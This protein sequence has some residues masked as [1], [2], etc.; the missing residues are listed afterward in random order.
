[1]SPDN[2][3]D[4][5]SILRNRTFD[6]LA[7]GE[8]ASMERTLTAQD[9]QL[10]AVMS[11]DLNPQHLDP[12]F[13]ASTRFHGVIAHGMWG[14]A[15]I[16]ALLGTRLPGPGTVYQ[17]QTLRF[18]A[19]VRLG[20][21]L[22][23]RVQVRSKNADTQAVVLACTGTNQ[24]GETVIEGEADVIAPTERIE[25]PRS[26]LPDISVDNGGDNGLS[27]T[28]V[29]AGASAQAAAM[30]GWQ[31]GF[32]NLNPD[33]TVEYD[34]IGSGGGRETFLSGGSAFAG[35]DS[36]LNDEEYEASLDSCPGD[37]G[38]VHLPH[39]ISPVAIAFN[40]DGVDSLNMTPETVAGIFAGE[41]TEWDDEAIAA[42][43]PDVD[44]PSTTIN[45]V[46]RSDE[47]GTT[48]NFTDYLASV[49]GDV[50][51]HGEVG[52]WPINHGEG[53]NGTTLLGIG[54]YRPS[55]VVSNEEICE[56]IDSTTDVSIRKCCPKRLRGRTVSLAA[57]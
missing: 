33:V 7:I 18:L 48:E 24:N 43:N 21:R 4:D 52:E 30:K 31:A 40:L 39:Y 9:I 57:P 19:P 13:A 38:A 8:C 27:G 42:D 56:T 10:F 28:L 41:I 35:T 47:S 46:H 29:G 32:Q 55:R 1:M 20:D 15:L 11:G 12:E 51:T 26:A 23:I 16:S 37:L 2:A 5:L 44:L 3:T 17:G 34:P 45:P 53:A 50:W 25:R 22:S 6:E 14:G 36:L 54:A 49:A